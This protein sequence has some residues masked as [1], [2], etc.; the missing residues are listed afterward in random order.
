M[1]SQK[2]YEELEEFFRESAEIDKAADR[3]LNSN[4]EKGVM[5]TQEIFNYPEKMITK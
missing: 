3:I 1:L 2:D 5:S 4:N